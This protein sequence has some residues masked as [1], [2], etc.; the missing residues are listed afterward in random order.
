MKSA[1]D[2]RQLELFSNPPP[3]PAKLPYAF[4]PDLRIGPWTLRRDPTAIERITGPDFEAMDGIDLIIVLIKQPQLAS[5]LSVWKITA[6][7]LDHWHQDFP[8]EAEKIRVLLGR[9]P[10]AWTE[11]PPRPV[12]TT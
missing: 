3:T 1:T 2:S 4:S 7:D 11:K 10:I 8:E 9:P 5:R 12:R 6:D